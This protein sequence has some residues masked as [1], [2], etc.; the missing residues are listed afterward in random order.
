MPVESYNPDDGV[1]LADE[2][3]SIIQYRG[4]AENKISVTAIAHA[5]MMLLT[6]Y[7]SS[8]P[9]EGRE[10]IVGI[11]MIKLM[12]LIYPTMMEDSDDDDSLLPTQH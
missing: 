11:L 12:E 9:Q 2:F 4:D 8:L 7:I 3:N 6:N 1:E 10:E 5:C